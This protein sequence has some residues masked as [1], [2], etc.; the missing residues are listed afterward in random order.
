MAHQS[1]LI[2]TDIEAYLAEH[3]RKDLL[4]L[5][6]C[7]SVDDGKST[8]IGRLLHDANLIYEDHL[9]ALE[10]D[11]V[12]SGTTGDRVDLALLMDGLKAER[13]QGI[14]IDVAYRYFSTARRKFIIADT[15]G[16]L[17]Y[18]RNMVT[19][20]SN[21]QL[22]IILIDAREGV[23]EQTRRHSYIASLLGIRHVVVAVNKMD[24][25]G[26]DQTIF[27]AI[28]D[29][30]L[31]F[32]GQLGDVVP[33]AVPIS[34]LEG[35]N[36]VNSSNGMGWFDGPPLMEHLETVDVAADVDVE[37]L[38]FPVQLVQ[39]PDHS[40]RG[41]AGTIASG[42]LRP[43]QPV[44]ALPSGIS[45]TVE[46]LVTFDGDLELAGPGD[47]VTVTLADEIDLSRGD[48][49][50]GPGQEPA[51]AHDIDA[52]VVW[53]AAD[54]VRPGQ[55]L[56]LQSVGGLSNV[57]LRA[58]HH[59]IDMATLEREP[60][61]C[62][63]LNDIALCELVVDR[64]L[65]LD[66]YDVNPTTGSF[67]LLDRLTNVTVA[68]GMIVGA[69]SAWDRQPAAG[70]TRQ[71]SEITAAERAARFDQQPATVVLTGMTGAGKTTIAR[72]LERRLFDRGRTV[73]RLDGEN[74]RTGISRDLG[75]SAEDRSENLRR[76]AEIAKLANDQGLICVVAVQAPAASV[77]ERV[78]EL[79]GHGRY[80]EV[81]LDADERVRRARDPH[82]LYQ[83]ADA[84]E[85]EP[86]P[87][88]TTGYDRPVDPDLHLDTGTQTVDASVQAIIELL[89]ARDVLPGR[90]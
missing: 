74:L 70:L 22:A 79:V 48:L 75:F 11:S 38:R 29:D 34:A 57:S 25:V 27:E 50:A 36:V 23:L 6:T 73:L 1:D 54:E 43:G 83:A 44:V 87:G 46:R 19:G 62:L 20:A 32:A 31:A 26:Y 80:V 82:G 15:P 81:F 41:F 7:G 39:R 9:I 76:A 66:P 60:A 63:G 10:S 45:S 4:R 67:I 47:A 42:I 86:L 88:V 35:D 64:E 12:V 71:P 68:A 52:T 55:Q 77:R 40:F 89:A 28:R 13:E 72:G 17:Q 37:R 61:E 85:I 58:I 49:L 8:L 33:Y 78:R 53:M 16:H 3:E 30:Y 21:C 65:L 84:G 18:T 51:R 90:R 24:L 56:L 59:R 69:A 14:T 2:A 5:L